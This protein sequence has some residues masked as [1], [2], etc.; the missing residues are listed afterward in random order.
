MGREHRFKLGHGI[1][2]AMQRHQNGH[3]HDTDDCGQWVELA[4][5]IDLAQRQLELSGREQELRVLVESFDIARCQRDGAT[6]HRICARPRHAMRMDIRHR[7]ERRGRIGV[8]AQRV[9]CS[10]FGASHAGFEISIRVGRQQLFGL[11]KCSP[12]LGVLRVELHG[13][14]KCLDRIAQAGAAC[15]EQCQAEQV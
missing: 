1:G 12:C 4:R 6:K 10:G 3:A 9:L 7:D 2:I 13:L 8:D 14:C 5:T 11:G 15:R